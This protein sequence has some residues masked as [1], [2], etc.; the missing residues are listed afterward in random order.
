MAWD[1]SW[2]EASARGEVF[3][4]SRDAAKVGDAV[5]TLRETPANSVAGLEADVSKAASVE[6]MANAWYAFGGVDV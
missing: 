5:A 3:V 4:T 6:A 2:R 1:L